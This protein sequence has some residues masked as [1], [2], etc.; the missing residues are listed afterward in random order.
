METTLTKQLI[1]FVALI[2]LF[3]MSGC[4]KLNIEKEIRIDIGTQFQNDFVTIK[5]DDYVVFSDSVST[6]P[7]LG[8]SEILIFDYPIGQYEISVKVNGVEKK[9]HFRHK[10]DRF[11]YL[12]LEESTSQ[13]CISYPAEKFV[14]D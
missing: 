1:L 11:I 9:D 10:Q 2:P 8:V 14:Y 5:L 7:I 6:N 4:K 13:I 3:V 12:S